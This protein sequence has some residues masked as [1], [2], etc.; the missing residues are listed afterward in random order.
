[1]SKK[2]CENCGG[3]GILHAGIGD[4]VRR[5]RVGDLDGIAR[6]DTC[7]KYDGDIEALRALCK[8]V[9]GAWAVY[10]LGHD[11]HLRAISGAT[12]ELYLRHTTESVANLQQAILNESEGD[13]DIPQ[14]YAVVERCEAG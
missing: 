11:G 8:K 13:G 7:M 14:V 1:M 2:P 12:P 10:A 5:G 3:R 9:G 6:C 4:V